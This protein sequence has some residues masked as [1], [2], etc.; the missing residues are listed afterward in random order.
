M[1]EA[2]TVVKQIGFCCAHRL[3]GYEGLC[4]R[5]HG[6]NYLVE[7]GITGPIRADGMVIDFKRLKQVIQR[8]TD[9][10]DHRTVL[11]VGDPLIEMIG[12]DQVRM[13][14]RRPTAENMAMVLRDHVVVA[15]QAKDAGITE[16]R[17]R[18][19]EARDSY[20][21]VSWRSSTG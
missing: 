8:I 1:S 14:A 13:M 18:L 4:G 19:W 11:E 2:A 3:R 9:Q 20:A 16:L 15:L 6:H 7:V 21:E 5:L 17:V 12:E 10:W